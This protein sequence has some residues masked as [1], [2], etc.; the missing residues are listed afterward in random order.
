[1]E[2]DEIR[3]IKLV[4]QYNKRLGR[5]DAVKLTIPLEWAK[6]IGID[7]ENPPKDLRVRAKFYRSERR[8]VLEFPSE[9]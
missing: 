6:E 9:E 2:P 4:L 8:I 5:V 1:M 7:F 3:T